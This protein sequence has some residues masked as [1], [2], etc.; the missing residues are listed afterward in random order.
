MELR[1]QAVN[2]VYDS[3]KSPL[4]GHRHNLSF[5]SDVPTS[6]SVT[7]DLPG[8]AQTRGLIGVIT[9]VTSQYYL[10]RIQANWVPVLKGNLL[11]SDST[12]VD[13]RMDF[14][15]LK[16]QK[17][18]VL[19]PGSYATCAILQ[20]GEAPDTSRAQY[21]CETERMGTP[22][23]EE[24][25]PGLLGYY[26]DLALRLMTDV[27]ALSRLA[28]NGGEGALEFLCH[29]KA[30]I[31][32]RVQ[33]VVG[34]LETANTTESQQMK[35]EFLNLLH[36]LQER[37]PATCES[38]HSARYDVRLSC[39]HKYCNTCQHKLV[40]RIMA[41]SLVRCTLCRAELSKTDQRIVALELYYHRPRADSGAETA[42][43][44]R[45]IRTGSQDSELGR[46]TL[47]HRAVPGS[48]SY[49]CC[50]A[51]QSLRKAKRR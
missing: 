11:H 7:P 5:A 8:K 16:L 50:Q 25:S 48:Q 46:C 35:Q 44:Q 28:E 21:N 14:K 12:P 40:Q 42:R 6:T 45:H 22:E 33:K 38:C 10:V 30:K 19:D 26:E 39:G 29:E 3:R 18:R 31:E 27:V 37:A 34:E 23:S 43:R 41:G 17:A 24:R 49:L 47:C 32:K 13:A 15:L 4:P 51:C 20:D 2:A 36:N 9:G 1:K